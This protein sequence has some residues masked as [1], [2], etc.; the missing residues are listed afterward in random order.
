VILATFIFILTICPLQGA[1]Q[2]QPVE[3][4]HRSKDVSD[5]AQLP[6]TPPKTQP[7]SKAY[8]DEKEL[9][10]D[11]EVS[12]KTTKN[13]L[14]HLIVIGWIVVGLMIVGMVHHW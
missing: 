13:S 14:T 6:T 10:M 1:Y 12:T 2:T 7:M 9:L 3:P 8:P 5:P 4:A 11:I